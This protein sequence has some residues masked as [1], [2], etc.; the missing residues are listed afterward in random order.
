MQNSERDSKDDFDS[1]KKL[2]NNYARYSALGFQMIV[3]IGLFTFIG[4]TIDE[5]KNSSTPLYTAFL[6]LLGVF[7]ALYLVIRSIKNLK[8]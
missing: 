3:I 4:Y 8:P 7:I 2:V 1:K 6:S 5:R